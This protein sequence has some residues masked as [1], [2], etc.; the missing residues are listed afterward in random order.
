MNEPLL[1]SFIVEDVGPLQTL[2]DVLLLYKYFLRAILSLWADAGCAHLCLHSQLQ[3][4]E[5]NSCITVTEMGYGIQS[6]LFNQNLL[7]KGRW[8]QWDLRYKGSPEFYNAVN[9]TS[10]IICLILS[11]GI[12]ATC[13]L[14]PEVNSCSTVY[15]S[16]KFFSFN[17]WDKIRGERN[18][19]APIPSALAGLI[20]ITPFHLLSHAGCNTD[21]TSQSNQ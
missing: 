13:R 5:P 7:P 6:L 18:V 14:Q 15:N 21:Q 20:G 3:A 2:L 12:I 11:L 4:V 1:T 8:W 10:D 17:I 19:L 9:K 16:W